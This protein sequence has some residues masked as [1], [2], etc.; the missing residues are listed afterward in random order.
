MGI[1]SGAKLASM[2]VWHKPQ[3][4]KARFWASGRQ[5]GDYRGSAKHQ[6]VNVVIVHLSGNPTNQAQ[7]A[8]AAISAMIVEIS[9]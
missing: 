4:P 6:T 8:M 9:D 7:L 1:I 2:A 3:E 5:T